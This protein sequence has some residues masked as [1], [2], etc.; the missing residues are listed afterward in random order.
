MQVAVIGGGPSGLVTLKYLLKA[1][2]NLSTPPVEA[3][4]FEANSDIGGVFLHRVY[5][6]AELVS[7]KFL[8]TFSDFRPRDGDPDFLPATRYLQYLNDYCANF[9]LFQSI[10]L[11]TVV[12][13]VKRRKNG[14][15]VVSY[16][17]KDGEA[18]EWEC[19]AV[20]VCS[21]LHVTPNIPFIDG[22]EKIPTVIHSA[23]F[24]TRSQFGQD[25]T[26]LILGTGETGMDIAY[27]AITSPTKRVVL[28]HRDGF[29]VVPKRAP[30][31]VM[32]PIFGKA[33]SPKHSPNVPID[34]IVASLFDTAYVHPWLRDGQAHWNYND[35]QQKTSMWLMS[36]TEEGLDQ[37]VGGISKQRY[38]AS[39]IFYTKSIKALPYISAPYRAIQSSTLS[40]RIRSSIMQLPVVDTKGRTIDLAPWP[41]HINDDGLVQFQNNG[42][43]EYQRLRDEK[44]KPDVLILATG[45]KQTFPF[46]EAEGRSESYPSA[47]DVDVRAV[48]KRNDPT[49]GFIGFVRPNLGAIPPLA[50]MQAQL[51]VLNLLAPERVAHSLLPEHERHYRLLPPRGSRINYGVE[52][53]AYAYQLALDI[54]GAAG[55]WE[56]L[57]A[58]WIGSLP[59]SWYK[60]PLVWALGS[61][62]NVKFRL[63]GPWKWDGADEV[64][65]EELWKTLKRRGGFLEHAMLSVLP[66]IYFGGISLVL[67]I[68]C[69][70]LGL[71]KR[72]RSFI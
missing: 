38:H 20:A 21:G 1:H 55:F 54:G 60:L 30:N 66:V 9:D 63:R 3:K 56:V 49:V 26:V 22:M 27:L 2:E 31:P 6:D 71:A 28:S 68:Y 24:K 58:G 62:Y 4:L 57:R 70:I 32:F 42:R 29:C 11:S 69:A 16:K 67:Y 15:H 5:E 44:I 35:S 18:A 12:L 33:S 52:H 72:A 7:S 10:Y 51:W 53:E 36:G 46:F 39:K 23:E 45:Y 19:N 50:E 64:L 37:W 65:V 25:Q 61:N 13:A 34:T 43:A 14:R 17:S 47:T 59:G 41:S 8:T 40:Q 48:W